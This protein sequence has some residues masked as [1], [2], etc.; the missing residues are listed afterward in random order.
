MVWDLIKPI[1]PTLADAVVLTGFGHDFTW[2]ANLQLCWGF[3][4]TRLN[5]PRQ[6]GGYDS[7][8]L[9][10][11]D[12]FNNQCAAFTYPYFNPGVLVQAENVK[13]PF[14][15][16]QLLSFGITNVVALDFKGLVLILNGEHDLSFCGDYCHG[17]LDA[18][19]SPSSSVFPNASPL[20]AYIHPNAGHAVNLHGNAT[21]AY[22]VI[23]AFLKAHGV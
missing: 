22:G 16:A 12:E 19:D 21:G 3:E 23:S 5:N 10:W 2:S 8:Y 6:F 14:A 7:G 15:I 18:A 11:G 9:T 4:L 13:A 20:A 17:V 1:N